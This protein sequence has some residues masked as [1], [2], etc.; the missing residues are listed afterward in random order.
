VPIRNPPANR[1]GKGLRLKNRREGSGGGQ[2]G[3]N[4]GDKGEVGGGRIGG[5][6]GSGG[7]GRCRGS[8]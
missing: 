1:T 5:G 8:G 7:R 4:L 6:R 2:D 3:V